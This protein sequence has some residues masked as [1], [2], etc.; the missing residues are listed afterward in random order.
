[1][2]AMEQKYNQPE[3]DCR[4]SQKPKGPANTIRICYDLGENA[5]VVLIHS[6]SKATVNA[7]LGK[8]ENYNR[9]VIEPEPP[10]ELL[11]IRN[12]H[13]ITR[14]NVMGL[15]AD[16]RHVPRSRAF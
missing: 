14:P 3:Q 10:D 4:N 2:L 5:V 8:H 1:M 7:A 15:H 11:G 12:G 13:H 9:L 6:Q 16:G